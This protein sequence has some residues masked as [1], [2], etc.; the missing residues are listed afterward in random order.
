MSKSSNGI[1]CTVDTVSGLVLARN[2]DWI[3][4]GGILDIVVWILYV[5]IVILR[6]LFIHIIIKIKFG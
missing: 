3:V 2:G 4:P 5:Y 6:M 1:I